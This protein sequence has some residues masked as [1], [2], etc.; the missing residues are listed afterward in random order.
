MV[1]TL[2]ALADARLDECRLL[3]YRKLLREQANN[4]ASLAEKRASDRQLSVVCIAQCRKHLE[5][6]K[7][8]S[9]L[10]CSVSLKLYKTIN[11][12]SGTYFN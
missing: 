1:L 6:E 11:T 12:P 5:K 4:A 2:T 7:R 9:D 8:T 10:L 3:S